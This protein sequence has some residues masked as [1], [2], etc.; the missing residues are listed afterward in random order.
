M[1]SSI[2]LRSIIFCSFTGSL[3]SQAFVVSPLPTCGNLLSTKHAS[4][5]SRTTELLAEKKRRRRKDSSE[6]SGA[7]SSSSSTS[8]RPGLDLNDDGGLPDFDMDDD[9]SVADSKDSKSSKKPAKAKVAINYNEISDNMM[10]DAYKP[11]G[12]LDSLIAD[13][14]LE[15][16]FEFEGEDEDVSIPDFTTLAK[17]ARVIEEPEVGTK[18]ARQSERRAAA[19]QAREAAEE[20]GKPGLLDLAFLRDEK[21]KISEIKILEK[22]AWLGIYILIGW[23]LFLNSPLFERLSP[24]IPV[25]FE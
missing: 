16:K 18:K 1:V 13:R 17:G 2:L 12:S 6:A 20:E 25:I 15:S 23:E 8:S 19:I 14:S 24:L 10:G 3:I 9:D 22:G 7:A 21:G 4:T 11:I 5:N